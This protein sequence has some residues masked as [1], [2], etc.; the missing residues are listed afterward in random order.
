M[1]DW[2]HIIVILMSIGMLLIVGR[3]VWKICKFVKENYPENVTIYS[4]SPKV[5]EYYFQHEVNWLHPDQITNISANNTIIMFTSYDRI[6]LENVH[7]M[8]II[9][10]KFMFLKSFN[11]KLFIYGSKNLA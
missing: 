4:T 9:E 5:T 2:E 7:V 6:D 1:Y 3:L 10:E 11:D 8:E